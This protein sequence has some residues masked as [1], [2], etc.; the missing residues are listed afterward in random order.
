M[1]F[2]LFVLLLAVVSGALHFFLP[3]LPWWSVALFAA[4]LSLFVKL[5][6]ALAFV[7]GFLGAALLWGGYAYYLD[8]LNEGILS[9]RMGI[10]FGGIPGSALP[11]VTAVFGGLVAG[12]GALTGSLIVK[13]L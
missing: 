9:A 6:P 1:R 12:L 10:L 4:L 2:I 11:L 8:F 13:K 3:F 5:S 7:A